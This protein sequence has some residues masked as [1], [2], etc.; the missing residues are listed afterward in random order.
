MSVSLSSTRRLGVSATVLLGLL[1]VLTAVVFAAA[2]GKGS[3]AGV[4]TQANESAIAGAI[5]GLTNVADGESLEV[6]TDQK[7]TFEFKNLAAGTYELSVD[8]DSFESFLS[9]E[10]EVKD[11]SPIQ[12]EIVLTKGE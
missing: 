8:H 1:L 4:V 12:M 5:V 6:T 7:G 11:G 9:E 3:V 2:A 10:L